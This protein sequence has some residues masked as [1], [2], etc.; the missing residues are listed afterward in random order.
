M[1]FILKKILPVVLVL[2]LCICCIPSTA[3][4]TDFSYLDYITNVRVDGDLNIVTCEFPAN[5]FHLYIYPEL[6]A[7]NP[8]SARYKDRVIADFDP[9]Q[10]YDIT[11]VPSAGNTIYM[12]NLPDDTE[13]N[14]YLEVMRYDASS[15][16][17]GDTIVYSTTYH[18]TDEGTY[19]MH[20]YME[21][22]TPDRKK[23]KESPDTLII[24]RYPKNYL[25]D[26]VEELIVDESALETAFEGKRFYD[27]MRV[28]Q[29][30]N[31]PTYLAD[32]VARRK[33][34]AHARNEVLFDR[35]SNPDNWFI[36]RN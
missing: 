29:R 4:A 35:L 19:G 17:V 26:K 10:S 16:V 6:D 14:L 31:D 1:I 11:I 30:R 36:N 32:K 23:D 21:W 15:G 28:A 24:T 13:M 3:S 12:G 9:Y 18:S 25:V 33:G 34:G 5:P 2:A 7:D 20:E 22:R 27:L 8:V